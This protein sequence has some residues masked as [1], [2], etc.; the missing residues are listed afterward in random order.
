MPYLILKFP[1][2]FLGIEAEI[3]TL[4]LVVPDLMNTPQVLIG[5]NSLDALYRDYVQKPAAYPKSSSY[6]YRAVLKVLE[7]RHKQTC[8]DMVGWVKFKG[9]TSEVE[10]TGSTVV[11]DGHV[12]VNHP[13][14]ENC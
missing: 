8:A 9:S 12:L 3:P 10:P 6:G 11:L 13:H 2:E 7:A 14:V 1:R 4:A 5:I